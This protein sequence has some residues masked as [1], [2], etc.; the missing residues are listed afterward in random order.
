MIAG[1]ILVPLLAAV[2][3]FATA[4]HPV[5]RAL[6]MAAAAVHT[7]LTVKAWVDWPARPDPVLDGWLA[8][9]APGLIF[10]STCS[11]LFL[12]AAVYGAGYLTREGGEPHRDIEEGGLFFR[13]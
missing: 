8:V 4:S 11:L 5:R 10:L 2:A 3:A 6:L 1:L 7:S 9:D 12:A 13:N